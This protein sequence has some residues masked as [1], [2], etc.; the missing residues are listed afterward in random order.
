MLA[1]RLF[2]FLPGVKLCVIVFYLGAV[3]RGELAIRGIHTYII[4]ILITV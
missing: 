4:H 2:V 1:G 3:K